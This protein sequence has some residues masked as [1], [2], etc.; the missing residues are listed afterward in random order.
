M[1]IITLEA[2]MGECVDQI[3]LAFPYSAVEPLIKSINKNS[4]PTVAPAAPQPAAIEWNSALEKIPLSITAQWPKFQMPTR[5]LLDLKPG[6]FIEIKPEHAEH[7]ELH[8]GSV[9]KF[10]GRLGTA[11]NKWAIQITEICKS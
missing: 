2:R 1:L 6:E 4:A 8:I 10:K 9:P 11:E 3:Q 7:I 5:A